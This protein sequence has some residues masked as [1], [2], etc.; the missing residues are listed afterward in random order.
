MKINFLI[1]SPAS[2]QLDLKGNTQLTVTRSTETLSVAFL[3]NSR[4]A[5]AFRV[6]G[7]GNPVCPGD[8]IV[9]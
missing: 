2:N 3:T 7:T 1:Q 6:P 9:R 5:F 8:L 4:S